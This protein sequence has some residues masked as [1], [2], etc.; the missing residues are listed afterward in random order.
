M[1]NTTVDSGQLLVPSHCQLSTVHCLLTY[2]AEIV[3]G[4][5]NAPLRRTAFQAV[6][7][8]WTN[9]ERVLR[10]AAPQLYLSTHR[11]PQRMCELFRQASRSG[12]P[13]VPTGR[14]GRAATRGCAMRFRSPRNVASPAD[15]HAESP[16][17]ALRHWS[18]NAHGAA[19]CRFA[20]WPVL[21]TRTGPPGWF[22]RRKRDDDEASRGPI[23]MAKGANAPEAIFRAK[24]RRFL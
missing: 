23:K 20:T 13:A 21:R 17:K 22:Q 11:S 19:S 3:P 14:P 12:G 9:G 18:S 7:A 2:L 6:P 8:V 24:P 1:T 5:E 15:I 4:N 10:L 16:A